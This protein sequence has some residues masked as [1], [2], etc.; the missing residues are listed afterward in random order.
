[1][2]T[3]LSSG[4]SEFPLAPLHVRDAEGLYGA[5]DWQRV[6][7]RALV[8]HYLNL[9]AVLDL[10]VEHCR[11]IQSYLLSSF[12]LLEKSEKIYVH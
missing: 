11:W 2:L 9:Q 12:S 5:L 8:R 10:T 6:G 1:M 7:A 3:K 4:L